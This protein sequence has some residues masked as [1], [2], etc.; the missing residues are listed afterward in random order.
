MSGKK[1]ID[2]DR[3][4]TLVVRLHCACTLLDIV[5]DTVTETQTADALYS[6]LETFKRIHED[7]RTEFQ[8]AANM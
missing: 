5:F 4:E 1:V 2:A 3:L 6:M 8:N 7:L